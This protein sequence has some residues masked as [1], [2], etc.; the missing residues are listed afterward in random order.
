MTDSISDTNSVTDTTFSG[1]RA[2]PTAPAIQQGSDLRRWP[3]RM[4]AHEWRRPQRDLVK[5]VVEY[6]REHP[7]VAA[8]CCLSVGFILGWKLKP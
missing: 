4:I 5:H 2:E 8:F 1:S 3:R 7:G 6:S